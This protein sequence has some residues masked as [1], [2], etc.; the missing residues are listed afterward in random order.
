MTSTYL[1]ATTQ[2]VKH[3]FKKLEAKRRRRNLKV[4]GRAV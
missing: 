1:N 2:G 4:V 3:A